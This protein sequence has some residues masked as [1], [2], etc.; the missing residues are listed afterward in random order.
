LQKL[1]ERIANEGQALP[2]GVIKVGSFLN[3]MI[4]TALAC[5]I[6]AEFARRFRDAKVNKILTIESSGIAF[7]VLTGV[8]L[9]VPVVFAKKAMGINTIGDAWTAFVR[10]YTKGTETSIFVNKQYLTQND[11]VL[12]IDDFL[13]YGEA[14][15][16][17][18]QMVR[19]SG[20]ALC[21]VGIVIEKAYEPGGETLRK[22]GIRVESL[23]RVSS[24]EG[25][26][27]SFL[28]Q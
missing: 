1:K 8:E 25:G 7:A 10:S 14:V 24:T 27:I 11:R 6:A 17:L 9:G 20:A 4:D 13:A 3:H 2:G 28:D 12:V 5:D 18:V 23:A 26:A 16:G 15:S 22:A 21:G 19:L